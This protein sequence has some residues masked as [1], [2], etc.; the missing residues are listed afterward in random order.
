[1]ANLSNRVGRLE[2]L[3]PSCPGHGS[4]RIYMGLEQSPDR[5]DVCGVPL[6]PFLF[7]ITFDRPDDADDDL[8]GGYADARLA[9]SGR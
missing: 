3:G 7:T 5:C 2:A 6:E 1:M 4:G 9:D 8:E